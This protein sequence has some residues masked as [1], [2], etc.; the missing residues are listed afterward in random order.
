MVGVYFLLIVFVIVLYNL[1]TLWLTRE[2]RVDK[3]LEIYV[4]EKIRKIKIEYKSAQKEINKLKFSE[5]KNENEF[6][7]RRKAIYQSRS[8][9]AEEISEELSI[10]NNNFAFNP[11]DI[12]FVGRF[13]D[14]IIFDGSSEDSEVN[15]YFVDIM[16]KNHLDKYDFKTQVENAIKNRNYS[17]QEISL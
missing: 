2:K 13:I 5:W 7:I 16:N 3:D 9:I 4:D 6:E 1:T 11:K 8:T 17:F 10:I 15:I 14:L 12:K